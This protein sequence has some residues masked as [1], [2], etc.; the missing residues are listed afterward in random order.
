MKIIYLVHL[1]CTLFMTGLCWFVQV[2][3]YPLFRSISLDTF[4]KYERKNVLLTAYIAVPIMVVESLSGLYLLYYNQ[5]LLHLINVLLLIIIGLS[6]FLF[7]APIHLK[8]MIDPSPKL[9]NRL[10][11]TNWI[12]TISW[13]IRSGIVIY[14]MMKYV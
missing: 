2:V 7:Q 14:F 6:T 12:R 3:H 9:I 1:V 11:H 8:L 5:T 10:I 13:S 4:K